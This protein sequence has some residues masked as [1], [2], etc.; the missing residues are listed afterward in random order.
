MY[1]QILGK[2]VHIITVYLFI[3][4]SVH[5]ISCCPHASQIL[6]KLPALRKSLSGPGLG[7]GL[8]DRAITVKFQF[9]VATRH[10]SRLQT[11][12]TLGPTHPSIQCVPAALS[13]G[14]KWPGR[15][16]DHSP[17]SN[18]EVKN[19]WS[20]TSTPPIPTWCA[21]G[22]L[23]FCTKHQVICPLS[24]K[25]PGLHKSWQRCCVFVGFVC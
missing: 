2:N 14:V 22:Q 19:E 15:E 6:P 1:R 17:P 9:P 12:Q 3:L 23:Y 16:V 7:Y 8:H 18:A 4:H 24:L 13:P 10:F 5:W 20:Y 21:Q 11:V 25:R